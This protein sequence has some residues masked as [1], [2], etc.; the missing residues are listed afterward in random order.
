MKISGAG[1]AI[2]LGFIALAGL[3]AYDA[4]NLQVPPS[5]ARVGPQVFPYIIAGG[6]ALVGL[7]LVWEAVR[8]P[9]RVHVPPM[10]DWKA[11]LMIGVALAA[12]YFIMKP[13]GFVF[14]ALI[15]FL[16][17]AFAFGSRKYAR[18]LVVG[19]VLALSAYVGFRYGLGIQLPPGIL[20]G[21]L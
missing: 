4:A 6:M 12:Q 15:L 2:G 7:R 17:I 21:L 18:D 8:D 9:I 1:L 11:V 14:S 19:L 3:V 20:K 5:Y 16:T 13:L 10:T